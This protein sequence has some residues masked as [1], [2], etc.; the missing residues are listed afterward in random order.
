[1]TVHVV[2]NVCVDTSFRLERLPQPGETLNAVDADDG[3]G[4][5]GAN[6]AAATARTGASVVLWAPV[7]K[8]AA[9]ERLERLLSAE[10][11]KLRLSRL[12][13][14]SDRSV[15]FVDRSGENVI[16]TA[17]A[18]AEAFDPLATTPLNE[19]W[20]S[21]DMLLTQGNLAQAVTA[22]CLK[23]A[24]EAGL[25][26]IVNPSPLAAEPLDLTTVSLLIVNRPE[27]ETLTGEADAEAAAR[28]LLALGAE[29]VIVTLG[30][31]GALVLE[32]AS[33]P[34]LRIPAGSVKAVD[35][36][37]AGDCFAG[38][39]TG[40]L[41]QGAALS[42]AARLATQAAGIAVGRA[43][44]LA[45]FPSRAELSALIKTLKLENV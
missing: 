45:S 44:T 35:A 37:G 11:L 10:P 8:D 25:F 23:A 36:S 33:S 32:T 22:A 4:G 20:R 29:S 13:L 43:G 16:V 27:A 31:A 38:T 2:G 6:Q 39:L 24:R 42:A 3:V 28:R 5:K 40:L 41:A 26:T 30:P 1:M 12:D 7:G 34:A 15:I 17:A 9:S 18:C 19:T 21:G 14:P